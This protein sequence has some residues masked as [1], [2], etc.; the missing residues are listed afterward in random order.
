MPCTLK[1]RTRWGTSPNGLNEQC[2]R[3]MGQLV[4]RCVKGEEKGEVCVG[5]KEAN[6]EAKAKFPN[7]RFAFISDPTERGREVSG[8]GVLLRNHH[9]SEVFLGDPST[10]PLL[11]FAF[12]WGDVVSYLTGCAYFQEYSHHIMI[13]E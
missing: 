13:S 1:T 5:W 8:S 3:N 2:E 10:L 7:R 11:K 6:R 9:K 4:A 12:L